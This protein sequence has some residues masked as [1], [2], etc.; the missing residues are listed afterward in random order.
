[1]VAVGSGVM[2]WMAVFGAASNPEWAIVELDSCATDMLTA[3]RDSHDYLTSN[4]FV[5][6]K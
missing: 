3:V 2:D 6:G 4:G 1:M 5:R